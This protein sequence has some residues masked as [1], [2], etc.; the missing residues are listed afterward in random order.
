MTPEQAPDRDG[1][2]RRTMMTGLAVAGVGVPLL[3]ACGGDGETTDASDPSSPA[4]STPAGDDSSAPASGDSGAAGDA[5]AS[6]E[7]IEVGGAVFLDEPS[8]V[9]TQPAEGEFHAFNR[10][11]THQGCPVADIVDGK[12]HCN[13]HGSLFSM[14]D[15]VPVPGS[16]ATQPLATV[17]ITVEGDQILPA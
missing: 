2:R 6:T 4:G 12:I 15:G 3:A 14:T 17:E 7:D 13:C 16:Q 8:V 1:V 10:A 5:L 11:C 9:I